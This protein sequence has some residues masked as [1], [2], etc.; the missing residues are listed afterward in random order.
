MHKHVLNSEHKVVKGEEGVERERK[1]DSK[2]I[3]K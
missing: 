2:Q 1:G 3:Y